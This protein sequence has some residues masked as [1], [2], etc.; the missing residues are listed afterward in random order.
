VGEF[1]KGPELQAQQHWRTAMGNMDYEPI[2]DELV[3]KSNNRTLRRQV[4]PNRMARV[5]AIRGNTKAALDVSLP[6]T[7]I[8]R[9]MDA[10]LG[11][12]LGPFLLHPLEILRKL[13]L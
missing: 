9:K 8:C 6:L 13:F 2:L 1:S 11:S 10:S 7:C 3:A 12:G 5:S 4:I